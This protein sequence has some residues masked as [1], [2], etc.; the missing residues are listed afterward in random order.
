MLILKMIEHQHCVQ[1]NQEHHP[2]YN[3]QLDITKSSTIN[4]Q[5]SFAPVQS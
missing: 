3:L 4:E 1:F 5:P 2:R